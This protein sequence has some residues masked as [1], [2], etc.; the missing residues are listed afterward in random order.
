MCWLTGDFQSH[1]SSAGIVHVTDRYRGGV[2]DGCGLI[3]KGFLFEHTEKF[4]NSENHFREKKIKY[5][6]NAG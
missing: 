6:T 2:C 5:K 1:V 3:L 4:E